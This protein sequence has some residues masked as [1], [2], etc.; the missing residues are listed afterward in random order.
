MLGAIGCER[1]PQR[2]APPAPPGISGE[3][4]LTARQV[5]RLGL[6][7]QPAGQRAVPQA[8]TAVGWFEAPPARE[9]VVRA[10]VAGMVGNQGTKLPVLGQ[11]VSGGVRLAALHVF[12]SP[13]DVAQLIAAKEDN[14]IILEQSLVSM[15]LAEEQLQKAVA[16]KEA[17]TG[18][19][20]NDLKEMYARS[21]AAYREAQQKLPFLAK[22]PYDE[23]ALL[24]PV[25]IDAPQAGVIT[26]V[27]AAAGQFV[28]A[29]DPLWTIAD[30]SRLWLRVP[31]FE[32]DYPRVLRERMAKVTLPEHNGL[33]E[34]APV[35]APQATQPRLRT[36]DLVY[37]V[38][39]AGLRFRPGQAATVSLPTGAVEL[40][41]VVPQSAVLWD[42][43]GLAWVYVREEDTHFRRARVEPGPADG[44]EFVILRGLE[45][46][47][48]VVARGA[49]ALYGEEF[50]GLVP[51]DDD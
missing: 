38:D 26:Q 16:A 50:K 49:A 2:G 10:P 11:P 28:A 42:G 39:N 21:Q 20:L 40:R 19:R 35:A 31:V 8:L 32:A 23:R 46:G 5:Q 43:G 22:E 12:L 30:W 36:V 27:H 48:P 33:L 17:V 47:T 24:R 51:A 29:G 13:Q 25:E 44:D 4:E 41:V 3:I 34:A 37:E 18:T 14:D 6:E 1:E 9:V 15:K 45:A 7:C